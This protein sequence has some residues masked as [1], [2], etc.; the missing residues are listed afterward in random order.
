[1]P[2]LVF[3]SL[4]AGFFAF[5]ATA[6]LAWADDAEKYEPKTPLAMKALAAK[7]SFVEVTDE[8]VA[9]ALTDLRAAVR[10][11]QHY[12][13]HGSIKIQDGWNRYLSLS[14]LVETVNSK[15]PDL[16]VLAEV[17]QKFVGPH[18]GL[19]LPAFRNVRKTI[20]PY[21]F[22]RRVNEDPR[23]AEK[24]NL[25]LELL[26]KSLD[27]HEAEPSSETANTIGSI[28][29]VLDAAEQAPDLVREVRSKF[30]NPN[31]VVR[32]S[33]SFIQ[34]LSTNAF[35]RSSPV[36]QLK[37]GATISGTAHTNGA[38][39][40][41]PRQ[42][43]DGRARFEL[44]LEGEI[45]SQTVASKGPAQVYV[46]GN[47]PIAAWRSLYFD[48][49]GFSADGVQATAQTHSRITGIST[50]P[51]FIRGIV[52]RKA[53][54]ARP[55][56]ERDAANQAR[57]EISQSFQK[58]TD[59]AVVK[60]NEAYTDKVVKPLTRLDQLSRLF[61]LQTTDTAAWLGWMQASNKQ[62]GASD[63]APLFN[64]DGDIVLAL[65]ESTLRNA[66]ASAIGGKSFD[67][68]KLRKLIAK[69]DAPKT[70]LPN[71]E[72]DAREIS[73]TFD[74]RLPLLV[75]FRNGKVSI[76]I[77]ILRFQDEGET[78][79]WPIRISA[80]FDIAQAGNGIQFTRNG[81]IEVDF[82]RSKTLSI[83]QVSARGRLKKKL[84]ELIPQQFQTKGLTPP[85]DMEQLQKIG[86]LRVIEASAN[87]GWL[88]VGWNAGR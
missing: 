27:K 44:C 14:E 58:Q 67:R 62:I 80:V 30:D 28:L 65:H 32:L 1:M 8:R 4:F 41:Y 84:D 76:A 72:E 78:R 49:N 17:G 20:E 3:R 57:N 51:R 77:N 23:M 46:T 87:N 47:T 60:L 59:E 22:L 38:V 50:R 61:Y 39:R 52:A 31:V 33:S 74:P 88:I 55:A 35:D 21:F 29:G 66:V 15:E 5:V 11:L 69:L 71:S 70:E 63:P 83:A 24:I 12:L 7:D 73:I 64:T 36:C 16:R 85:T 43:S 68:E 9:A 54:Q 37:D 25:Q 13:S 34:R 45:N 56:G 48:R 75:E 26:A 42:S 6:T 18:K 82:P 79:G 10:E 53:E 19:E 81:S 40:I 86:S 2:S